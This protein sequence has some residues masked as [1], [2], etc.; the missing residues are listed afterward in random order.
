MKMPASA[1][2]KPVYKAPQ[3]RREVFDPWNSASTGHQR[4]H[5]KL[6]GSEGWVHSRTLKLNAQL[7]TPDGGERISD[8]VGAG[9]ANYGKDGRTNTG[10]DDTVQGWRGRQGLN[11]QDWGDVEEMIR[12]RRR[13]PK[14]TESEAEDQDLP[15]PSAQPQK[16]DDR[17]PAAS[18]TEREASVELAKQASARAPQIFASLTVLIN[19]STYP[20][21]SDHKLKYLLTAHGA[22][23]SIRHARRQVTHVI[24]GKPNSASDDWSNTI[25]GGGGLA[26]S[27]LE[28]EILM[29]NL[30]L[31]K[32]VKYVGAEWYV[33]G[34]ISL[35]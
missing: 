25:A 2:F 24:V 19:G 32:G 13:L 22:R 27:K 10:W 6:S 1:P 35:R 20:I 15:P 3:P 31:G 18:S 11:G 34:S 23:I 30:A 26:G 33:F 4:A 8:L 7:T 12:D 17:D 9:S 16:E 28:K 29:K 14:A 21:V 5:N